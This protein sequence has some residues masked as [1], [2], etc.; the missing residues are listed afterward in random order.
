M[1]RKYNKRSEYWNDI[2]TKKDVL[3]SAPKRVEPPEI[4][5]ES[6]G[7]NLMATAACGGAETESPTRGRIANNS[8][9]DSTRFQNLRTAL[10]PY[11]IS[12]GK[13]S[14]NSAIDLTQRAY[15]NV[16]VFRNAVEVMVEF[17]TANLHLKGGNEKSRE[18]VK[19]WMEKIGIS[20]LKEEFFRE[21]YRSGNVFMYRFDG[22]IKND[23]FER[24]KEIMG[25]KSNILPLR[26]VVL[27]P[28]NI[29]VE[30][31][32]VSNKFTYVKML[33]TYEIER[34]KNPQTE[35][36]KAMFAALPKL[37]R[38]SISSYGGGMNRF[39]YAPIDPLRLYYVFYKKQPYEP[40]AIPM[41]YPILND[42]EWKLQLKKMDMAISRSIEHAILIITTG[43]AVT[44]YG[45][46]VNPNNVKAIQDLFKNSTI[47]RVLVADYTT[48]GEWLIP[49]FKEL[50]GPDKYEIVDRDIKEG[51]QTI[52]LGDDKFANAMI[53]AK[54]FIER[55]KEGQAA[56]LNEF[57]QEEINRI[58]EEMNFKDTP[59][60]EFEDT[61]LQDETQLWR[62]FV[63]LGELGFLTPDQVNEA[64]KTGILPDKETA[65]EAQKEY[66]KQRDN[67]LFYPQ[68]GGGN[69]PE[70]A[71][72]EN[73]V[74]PK[75]PSG[76]GRPPGSK[77]PQSTKRVSPIGTGSEENE[78]KFGVVKISQMLNKF[79]G[80]KKD[81]EAA[82]K[83]KFK[84]K[85]LTPEQIDVAQTLAKSIFANESEKDWKAAIKSY[86]KEPKEIN[87]AIAS[88]IDDIAVRYDVDSLMAL[89][90]SKS[91]ITE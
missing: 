46:G 69:T 11:E 20:K 89:I 49:D 13:M 26:Y 59:V 12:N 66:K 17:S 3:A 62:T 7:S 42:I 1:P 91:K 72:E 57:F 44:Q 50:I 88:E 83:S 53:K 75:A 4:H 22:K 65:L 25:T 16:A 14:I 84:I 43:E 81:A 45:G 60:A 55:L 56:F 41:G 61:V 21:Y 64:I 67:G 37:V 39:I 79:E 28:T 29:F 27:N 31:G 8:I 33:S 90:L 85:E 5:Y 87:S 35:E 86:I 51:L 18:F 10:L 82:L 58:C 32:I 74:A 40:L 71:A 15:A 36:E 38:D 48:K 2:K 63:R 70:N 52:L 23:V 80:L 73:V 30:N 76:G 68:V 6:F 19:S 54:I 77:A 9:D 34:L 78:R 47:G 24:M